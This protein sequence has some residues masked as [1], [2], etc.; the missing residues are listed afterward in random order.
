MVVMTTRVPIRDRVELDKRLKANG[1][2][3]KL[4]SNEEARDKAAWALK[5]IRLG[6]L[7]KRINPAELR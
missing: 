7:R 6:S 5:N 1:V 4:F 2:D 3:A